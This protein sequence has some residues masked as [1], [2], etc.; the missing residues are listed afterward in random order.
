MQKR[1]S[2]FFFFFFFFLQLHLQHMKVPGLG[3]ELELQLG[4]T[5]Q[6]QQPDPSHI[7]DLCHSLWQCRILPLSKAR[8]QTCILTK[9]MLG[10]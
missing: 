10:P 3:V 2:P 5:P 8:D 9:T 7:C 1:Q 6:P 4:P